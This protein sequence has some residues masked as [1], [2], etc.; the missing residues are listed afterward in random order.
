MSDFDENTQDSNPKEP[1]AEEKKKL[2]DSQLRLFQAI[3]GILCAAALVA[4]MFLMEELAKTNSF[5]QYTF[6]IVFLVIMFGRRRIESKY[7]LRL[8]LF[9]LVL[10]DGIMGGILLFILATPD[11][12]AGQVWRLV[13]LIGGFILMAG[14]GI[15]W[16]CLR[17][18]KRKKE[19]TVP[20]IRIPEKKEPE[21]GEKNEAA[22]DGALTTEQKIA[23]MMRDLED[24]E[25]PDGK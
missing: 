14:L 21:E 20:P 5:L 18:L 1:Q 10:I 19:G 9:G 16:P 25:K 2:T 6:L 13:I 12:L 3:A 23:A 24:R 4:S 11:F 22:S 8:N 17:Y 7:R 15:V